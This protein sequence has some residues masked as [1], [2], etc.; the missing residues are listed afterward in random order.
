MLRAWIRNSITSELQ[1]SFVYITSVKQFWE[2]IIEKYGQS[3]DITLSKLKR[4]I[5]KLKQENQNLMEYY[6][7]VHML[8]SEFKEIEPI[9]QCDCCNGKSKNDLIVKIE[10]DKMIQFFNGL[11]DKYEAV[12]NQLLLMDPMPSMSK[13]FSLIL[14]I[15]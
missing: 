1:H 12:K 9:N 4:N 2:N 15:E 3:N 10:R 7:Q 13:I 14:Q 11:N 6:S 5:S 8:M